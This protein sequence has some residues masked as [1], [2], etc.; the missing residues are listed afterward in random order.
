MVSGTPIDEKCPLVFLSRTF[1]EIVGA[2]ITNRIL[3]LTL[4]DLPP[5]H[6][7]IHEQIRLW[8]EQRRAR[9]DNDQKPLL[10]VLDSFACLGE[11]PR[12]EKIRNFKRVHSTKDRIVA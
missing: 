8:R 12:I 6:V 10:P 5:S 4:L 2:Q 9:A 7:R 1:F 3:S 11:P